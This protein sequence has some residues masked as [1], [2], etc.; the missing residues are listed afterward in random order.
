MIVLVGFVGYTE[1]VTE[2]DG[3]SKALGVTVNALS[4][5]LNAIPGLGLGDLITILLDNALPVGSF[6]P[7]WIQK[8][9]YQILSC[10][11]SG[12]NYRSCG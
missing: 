6:N 10:R 11:E 12:R 2:Y 4:S 1:G 5:L 7:Y 9:K 3:L 8:C